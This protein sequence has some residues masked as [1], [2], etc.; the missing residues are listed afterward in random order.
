MGS[1]NGLLKAEFTPPNRWAL[2]RE[3]SFKTSMLSKDEIEILQWIGVDCSGVGE[4]KV[5]SGFSTDLASVPRYLWWLI[6]PTDIVRASV[7]HDE[8]YFWC[9]NYFNSTDSDIDIWTKARMISDK[10]FLIAMQASEPP[11]EKWKIKAIYAAVRFFGK[12]PASAI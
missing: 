3:L 10:V 1:Y 5:K 7:I 12:K 8:L 11:I 9:R 2:S 6:S 4:I